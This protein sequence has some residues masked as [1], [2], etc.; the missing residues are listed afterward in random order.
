MHARYI[1][2]NNPCTIFLTEASISSFLVCRLCVKFTAVNNSL[3]IRA[4]MTSWRRPPVLIFSLVL[5][6]F[7]V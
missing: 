1:M 6:R 5:D 4:F 2:R 7:F 3:N